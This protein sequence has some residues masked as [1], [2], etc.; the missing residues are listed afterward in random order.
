MYIKVYSRA[1][2]EV[3]ETH[4]IQTPATDSSQ[5]TSCDWVSPP[6]SCF[7][8]TAAK[9]RSRGLFGT[10][11]WVVF[12]RG[13]LHSQCTTY[14]LYITLHV[15]MLW[16][17]VYKVGRFL[18]NDHVVRSQD[19]YT[20]AN[21]AEGHSRVPVSFLGFWIGSQISIWFA[22]NAFIVVVSSPVWYLD[23]AH[24]LRPVGCFFFPVSAWRKFLSHFASTQNVV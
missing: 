24:M 17:S 2:P 20:T 14:L 9:Q 23:S 19:K 18:D 3:I 22:G 4:C 7:F 21:K 5:V 16:P 10:S 8:L 11:L 1:A 12:V 6:C 13:H 15:G